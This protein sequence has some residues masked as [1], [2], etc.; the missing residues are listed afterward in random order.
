M[1]AFYGSVHFDMEATENRVQN[2]MKKRSQSDKVGRLKYT[3]QVLNRIEDKLDSLD[4]RFTRI[5]QGL[6]PSFVF[7]QSYIEEAACCDEV[8]REI[9]RLLFEA[10]CPGLLPKDLAARLLCFRIRRFQV[11]RRIFRMNKRLIK[12]LGEAVAEQRGWHWALTGFAV[13]A[14]GSVE[15]KEHGI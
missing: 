7:E 12:E 8:D 15:K 5:E 14:W 2:S 10:G 6:K 9:L 3:L 4:R 1:V 13:E 11:S